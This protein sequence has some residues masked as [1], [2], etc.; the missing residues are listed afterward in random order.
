MGECKP[1]LPIPFSRL[2]LAPTDR[3]VLELVDVWVAQVDKRLCNAVVRPRLP[4]PDR[5]SPSHTCCNQGLTLVHVRAQLE[6]IRDT[7]MVQVGLRGA[8]RQ[9]KLS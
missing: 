9:L 3:A 7:M 4:G 1:L 8:Q 5:P 6:H 2:G